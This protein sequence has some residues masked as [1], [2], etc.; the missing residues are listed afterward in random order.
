VEEENNSNEKGSMRNCQNAHGTNGKVP[1]EWKIWFCKKTN[2]NG[3]T[4][5]DMPHDGLKQYNENY[6]AHKCI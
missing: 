4:E 2:T 3:L 1:G 6:P 5:K